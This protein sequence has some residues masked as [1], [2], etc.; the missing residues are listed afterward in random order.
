[1]AV[2][3]LSGSEG[4]SQVVLHSRQFLNNI[5]SSR[6]KNKMNISFCEYIAVVL[7]VVELEAQG[8]QLAFS[9]LAELVVEVLERCRE[10]TAQLVYILGQPS[11]RKLG[12]LEG[13]DADE[14]FPG[15]TLAVFIE[16][17]L[18]IVLIVVLLESEGDSL[19]VGDD[20]EDVVESYH[21]LLAPGAAESGI[22]DVLLELS[23]QLEHFV[24]GGR[25]VQG[26]AEF[27]EASFDGDHEVAEE[28]VDEV[29][30]GVAEDVARVEQATDVLSS[31]LPHPDALVSRLHDP[32]AFGDLLDLLDLPQEIEYLLVVHHDFWRKQRLHRLQL[33]E[34]VLQV[35]AVPTL[36]S[37]PI[38]DLLGKQ[39]IKNRRSVGLLVSQEKIS[40]ALPD[41]IADVPIE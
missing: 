35:E 15:H 29:V 24:E 18:F 10:N 11:S 26:L 16:P 14:T 40:E 38:I 21:D 4:T 2:V 36:G 9:F 41:R 7:T 8:A 17:P 22:K 20:R 33:F 19:E 28:T 32:N 39:P 3:F 31:G 30:H 37:S 12:H 1:V 13:I 34:R 5:G 6:F 25:L 27:Q 23:V